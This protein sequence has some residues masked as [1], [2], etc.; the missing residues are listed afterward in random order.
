[1]TV[2]MSVERT[3]GQLRKCSLSAVVQ[4]SNGGEE[5]KASFHNSVVQGTQM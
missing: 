1:M 5:D 3:S 4:N 2:T